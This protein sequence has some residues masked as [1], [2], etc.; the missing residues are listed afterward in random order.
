[1]VLCCLCCFFLKHPL[2]SILLCLLPT[3]FRQI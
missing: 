3:D 1:M 2:H